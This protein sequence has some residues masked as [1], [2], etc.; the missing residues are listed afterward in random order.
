VTYSFNWGDG[1][2]TSGAS[3]SANHLYGGAGDYFV[4]LT[5]TDSHGRTDTDSTTVSV[6]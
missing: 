2:V 6:S 5:V 4:S 1:A 3:A